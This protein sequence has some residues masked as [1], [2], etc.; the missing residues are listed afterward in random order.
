MQLLDQLE[1]E[2]P[3]DPSLAPKASARPRLRH[4]SGRGAARAWPVQQQ[5]QRGGVGTDCT[6]STLHLHPRRPR[7][8][9]GGR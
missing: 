9:R 1:A 6:A 7:P 8:Q 2:N 5:P 3:E 4:A